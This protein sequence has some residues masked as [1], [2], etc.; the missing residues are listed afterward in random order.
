MGWYAWVPFMECYHG[1]VSLDH[2]IQ[3][4]LQVD[5]QRVD[6]SGGR[7]YIEKDWGPSFPSAWIWL[8]T[9]H[10]GVPGTSLTASIAVIPWMRSSFSGFIVGFLHGGRL[11]RLATY[12]GA[13]VAHL[14]GMWQRSRQA[15]ARP[16]GPNKPFRRNSTRLPPVLHIPLLQ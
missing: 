9:N 1:I 12:T 3:G 13:K 14:I 7:G 4:A 11:Y 6:F 8:Q 5:G 10:F 15:Q 2:E 16:F